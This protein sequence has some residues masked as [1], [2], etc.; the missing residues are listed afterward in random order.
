MEPSTLERLFQAFDEQ[1]EALVEAI[2]TQTKPAERANLVQQCHACA[3]AA[4][5]IGAL[6]LRH[7][8]ADLETA[9]VTGDAGAIALGH[10]TLE[11]IW[12]DIKATL[13]QGPALPA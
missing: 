8:V 13:A 11:R 1:I 3:G 2:A 4:A 7:C 9:Y 10:K 5:V 6:Q 12:P